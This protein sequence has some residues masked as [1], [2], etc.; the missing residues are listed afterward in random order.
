LAVIRRWMVLIAA[1]VAVGLL[2]LLPGAVA[3]GA[4]GPPTAGQDRWLA[5]TMLV[6][7][8]DAGPA[9][10]TTVTSGCEASL[11]RAA[12]RAGVPRMA[13]VGA[14]F[15]AGVGPGRPH[16]AWPVLLAHEL[17]W[18]AAINGVPS[19]GYIRPG[20]E[21]K[22]PMS[23]ELRRVDLASF[24]PGL[25]IV[26]AGHDDMGLPTALEQLRV[27]QTVQL[28]RAQAPQAR[29]ALLTV[30]PGKRHPGQAAQTD[31]AIVT[32]ARSV[33]PGV[34]IMDPLTGR[35]TF[36]RAHDGLHPTV[37]GD[38]WIAAKVASLLRA[39]GVTAGPAGGGQVC[40]F[41]VTAPAHPPQ[42][43]PPHPP[44]RR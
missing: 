29:I 20:L 8:G 6:R 16:L 7:S 37:A 21:H 41:A 33:D 12:E 35:W 3:W 10:A 42:P 28:I 1:G 22:G 24:K 27:R 17:R 5:R 26:Q 30:F 19:A 36:Q 38:A 15:T 25:V 43:S 34:I 23:A 4:I 2:A 11:G 32:A 44:G 31:R 14:S 18:D 39:H 13:I 40:D 9:P